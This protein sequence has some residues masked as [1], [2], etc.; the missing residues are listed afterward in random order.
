MKWTYNKENPR[1]EWHTWFAWHPVTPKGS[2]ETVWLE[3]IQRKQRWPNE[4]GRIS[5]FFDRL[6]CAIEY[7]YKHV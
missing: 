4:N 7:E 3:P 1:M 6:F 2:N 5:T